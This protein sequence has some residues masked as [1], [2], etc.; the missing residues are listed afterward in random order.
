M[1]VVKH[2]KW[3]NRLAV[4]KVPWLLLLLTVILWTNL[5]SATG[6]RF[7]FFCGWSVRFSK[8]FWHLLFQKCV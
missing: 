6:L 7:D 2:I 5:T 8:G 4:L 3:A 1:K